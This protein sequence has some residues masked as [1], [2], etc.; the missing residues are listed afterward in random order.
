MPPPSPDEALLTQHLHL[1][2]GAMLVIKA[3]LAELIRSH[4]Q[5]LGFK[6]QEPQLRVAQDFTLF[7]RGQLIL[8]KL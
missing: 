7:I 3:S 2:V 5:L 4:L 6:P 8:K 1:H